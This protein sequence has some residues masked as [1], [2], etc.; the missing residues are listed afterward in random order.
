MHTAQC[1]GI[2]KSAEPVD[3]SAEFCDLIGP[4]KHHVSESAN[5]LSRLMPA[6]SSLIWLA[7][8]STMFQ[9]LPITRAGWCQRWVLWSDWPQEA[10]CFR[11]CQSPE[12]VDASAE[13]FDLIG[14]KKHNVSESANHLS[15]LM[16]ALSSWS[17]WPQEAQ[18]FRICQ[19]PEPVDA[20]AEFFDLIGPK[21]HN[22]S[23]S[24][25]HLS[26][27]MP[28]LSSLIWL[29]PRSTM[30]QNLPITWADWCQRWVLWSDWLPGR[31]SWAMW[32][33]AAGEEGRSAGSLYQKTR[34]QILI[35]MNLRNQPVEATYSRNY[36]LVYILNGHPSTSL[37]AG[38]VTC[39]IQTKEE[40]NASFLG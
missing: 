38:K 22:V 8:R 16:P 17:D 1:F 23:E 7:P 4:Q 35:G 18:C 15:R 3:V 10:P 9:N 33:P 27:L 13:F 20:S 24:A 28:A 29:A 30:F 19:S 5:H 21:K 37:D 36:V 32:C 34:L 6:L 39:R 11:I 25:N 40:K 31:G 12:P 26:R 2:C 14:P